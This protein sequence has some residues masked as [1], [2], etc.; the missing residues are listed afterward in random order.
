MSHPDCGLLLVQPKWA[1]AHTHSS[2]APGES[3]EVPSVH[4]ALGGQRGYERLGPMLRFSLAVF[5]TLDYEAFSPAL[6]MNSAGVL[7]LRHT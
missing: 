7:R 3:T 1:E 4:Q 5:V 6:F 2:V